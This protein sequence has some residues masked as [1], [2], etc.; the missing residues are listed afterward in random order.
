[1]AQIRL[2][3]GTPTEVRRTLSRILNMVANGEMESKTANTIILGCKAVLSSIRSDEQEKKIEE[4][5][6]LLE[7]MMKLYEESRPAAP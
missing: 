4:L 1:M 7:E 3:L 6:R 5:N 2:R